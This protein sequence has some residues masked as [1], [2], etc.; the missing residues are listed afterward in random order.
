MI[1]NIKDKKQEMHRKKWMGVKFEQGK[2]KKDKERLWANKMLNV[3]SY[4][5][6]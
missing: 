5:V 2:K 6:H 3:S 1:E 4:Q